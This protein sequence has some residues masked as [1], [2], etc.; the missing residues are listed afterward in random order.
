MLLG[1]TCQD[2]VHGPIS[3]G[4]Y[5]LWCGCDYLGI[6]KSL[7]F[8][9]PRWRAPRPAYNRFVLRDTARRI[10]IPLFDSRSTRLKAL[11]ASIAAIVAVALVDWKIEPNLSLG[12]LY[13]FPMLV[14]AMFCTRWQ[15]VAA[16]AGCAMLREVLSPLPWDGD[17]EAR[18]LMGFIAFAGAGLF[19]AEL[20]RNRQLALQ[21]AAQ[22]TEQIRLRE[23][24]EQEL[25]VLVES[26]P[27][28]ILTL[29]AEG[30]VLLANEAAHRLFGFEG[31]GLAGESLAPYLPALASAVDH[32]AAPLRTNMECLGRRQGGQG[33]LAHVWFSTYRTLSGTRLAA[34]VLDISEQLRDR[35]VQGLDWM[36]TASRILFGAVSHEVRNLSAA[37]A[38]ARANLARTAGLADNEDFKA[39]SALVEGLQKISSS[40][41]RLS[42]GPAAQSVDLYTV[43]DELRI[44]LEPSFLEDQIAL[45]W[46][47]PRGLP[48]V[49][50]EHQNLLQVF[51]NL[52]QN[53]QRELATVGEKR[54][55]VAAC[56]ERDSIVIRFRDTGPGVPEPQELFRPFHHRGDAGG[57][58]L[59]VSRMIA[60]SFA[61]DV[62]YEPQPHG[63]CF[64]VRLLLA[65]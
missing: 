24:L 54:L 23:E 7:S 8:G 9:R 5:C 61:G 64:A 41:L 55:T 3:D 65:A 16:A 36:A 39:L 30:K 43:L 59:F 20:A 10:R 38:V 29:D 18:V 1:R 34:I 37:A 6:G 26:S 11:V 46:T 57:L 52:A 47:I 19:V 35:E 40:E 44:V 21:H 62:R 48:R 63:S 50:G 53:A 56:R 28:A 33:F 14:L 25:R 58:G 15:I 12:F 31:E 42:A 22:L 4:Q 17:T 60:R 45:E 27:A 32:A 2:T 51:L 49:L 13:V